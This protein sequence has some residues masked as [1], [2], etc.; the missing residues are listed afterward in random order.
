MP[1]AGPKLFHASAIKSGWSVMEAEGTRTNRYRSNETEVEK[2]RKR[3]PA[4]HKGIII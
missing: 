1:L 4:S 3:L 2:D